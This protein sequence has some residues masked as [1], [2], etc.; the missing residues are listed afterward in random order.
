MSGRSDARV[1]L[2]GAGPGDPGLLTLRAVECLSAADLIIHDRLVA[3]RVLDFAPPHARRVPVESLRG[4]ANPDRWPS[5]LS[6]MVEAVR[7]GRRVVRLKGG[8]PLVFGRGGEEAEA[9]RAVGIAYEVV[10]GVT[11]GLGA[12]AYADVPL[13]H[14]ACA[15]AVALVTGHENPDKP[16]FALDW[17]ALA[18]FPGTLVIYMGYARLS[19][20]AEALIAHGKPADTPVAVVSRATTGEQQSV[21]A[22]LDT[23]AQAVNRAGLVPPAVAM[24]GPVVGLR[25]PHSWFE[26]LPLVGRRVLVT[27]PRH[28]AGDFV[29]KLELEGAVPEV[30]P[31]VDIVPLDDYSAVDDALG[32]L[33]GFD[34]LVFTSAN[35]V[36]AFFGRLD[37]LG[38]DARALGR[39]RVAAIGPATAAAL[40]GV[41]V[42]ADLVPAEYRSEGLAAALAP[43][44][45]GKRV[46]LARAD[47]GRDV[48]PVELQRAGADIE[49]VTVY[50]QTDGLADAPAVF[51]RLR[52]AEIGYVTLTSPN[53]ARV[54][55]SRLDAPTQA[56]VRSGSVRLATI[57][58]VTSAAVHELGFPVAAE[59][60][61]YTTDGL[62]A[63]LIAL[64]RAEATENSK[65]PH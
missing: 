21:T 39:C 60:T 55:L 24:V 56:R 28:Q 26:E 16:E 50:R 32:R 12:A 23:I 34:W 7:D 13:T 38:R 64:V 37:V 2:V 61:E 19:V 63:A 43:Y 18:Q 25:P 54:L 51:D 52:T 42:K 5:I 1:Y 48:L 49:Q 6:L 30:L 33:V 46:L 53:V 31:A 27:R 58:P 65:T 59:A 14:R 8:D 40:A 35:G 45:A 62:L 17:R 22:P 57:S 47:R 29:R 4:A 41:R 44:V 36:D 15:S 10:P 20:L 9:L 3:P 11:A